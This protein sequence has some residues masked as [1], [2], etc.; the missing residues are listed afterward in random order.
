MLPKR[1]P[2]S[3]TRFRSLKDLIAYKGLKM[4]YVRDQIIL[5]NRNISVVQWS[6][7]CNRKNTLRKPIHGLIADILDVDVELVKELT[8]KRKSNP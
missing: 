5:K 6:N 3:K 1:N 7:V 8:K 4:C 2:K